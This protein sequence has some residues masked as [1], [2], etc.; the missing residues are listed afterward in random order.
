M[1]AFRLACYA[2]EM[3]W[4]DAEALLAHPLTREM[5]PQLMSALSSIRVNLAEGYSRSA[6][7][8][9]ARI[10]EYGLGSVRESREWYRQGVPVLGADLVTARC[11]VLDEI[12]RMLLAI[13]P[14][15]RERRIAPSTE[16][17]LQDTTKRRRS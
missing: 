4:P 5:A 7:R 6:G 12:T 16:P 10:F 17:P 2:A 3:A 8:D 13:I 15:E 9:R 11:D 1:R 14:R